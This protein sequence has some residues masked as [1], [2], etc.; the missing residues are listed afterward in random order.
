MN[1]TV[2]LANQTTI[3]KRSRLPATKARL[4]DSR[5]FL[6]WSRPEWIK[7]PEYFKNFYAAF[8][9]FPLARLDRYP[10]ME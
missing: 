3:S 6:Y 5:A 8:T 9:A 7:Q 10:G 2:R 4:S 1:P